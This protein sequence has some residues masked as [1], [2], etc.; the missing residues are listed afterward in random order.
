MDS[1][2]AGSLDIRKSLTGYVFTMYGGAFSWKANLQL[3]VALS[4]IE[5]KYIAM[6]EAIKEVI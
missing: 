1:D 6:T 2:Y 3:V 4:T 5:T